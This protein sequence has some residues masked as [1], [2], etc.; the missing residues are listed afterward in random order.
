MIGPKIVER[1][2]IAWKAMRTARV[3]GRLL[4]APN[5]VVT[6]PFR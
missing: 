1:M 6:N 5:M 3:A 2:M 4:W